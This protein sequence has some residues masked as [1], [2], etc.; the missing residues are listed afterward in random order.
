MKMP[1][2]L[3]ISLLEV[4]KA[5]E[6]HQAKDVICWLEQGDQLTDAELRVVAK[7]ASGLETKDA[8]DALCI[9]HT[10]IRNHLT[11]I[12]SKLHINNRVQLTL[13]AIRNKIITVD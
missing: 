13:W 1:P 3:R 7:I 5:S 4:L 9:T 2:D 10:T 11:N 8:A 6:H 12:M